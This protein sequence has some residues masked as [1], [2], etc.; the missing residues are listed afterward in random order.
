MKKT[1]TAAV[2]SLLLSPTL[3][4]AQGLVEPAP[5]A[6]LHGSGAATFRW[7]AGNAS[8]YWLQVGTAAG[9][10]DLANQDEGSGLS[11]NLT[12]LPAH[13]TVYVRLWWLVGPQW[14]YSDSTYVIAGE[15]EVRFFDESVTELG[16]QLRVHVLHDTVT[17]ICTAV[18]ERWATLD[19]PTLASMGPV[20]CVVAH[21]Q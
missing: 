14:L 8:Q 15:D 9:G 5:G 13:G 6:A 1:L 18:I 17:N 16:G 4:H 21:P 10:H 20:P 11:A 2:L 19:G 12:G 7:S 3:G